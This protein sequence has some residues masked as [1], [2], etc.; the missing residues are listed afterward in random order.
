MRAA[1]VPP[2]GWL[3]AERADRSRRVDRYPQRRPTEIEVRRVMF[4]P[5]GALGIRHDVIAGG[6]G[7][8]AGPGEAAAGEGF[9]TPFTEWRQAVNYPGE[10]ALV[11]HRAPR[12]RDHLVVGFHRVMLLLADWRALGIDP[13]HVMDLVHVQLE[14]DLDRN[15]QLAPRLVQLPVDP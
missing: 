6:V 5:W 12:S 15:A 3:F 1:W 14:V 9:Q 7:R 2:P 4:V 8:A 13:P 10:I 11:C